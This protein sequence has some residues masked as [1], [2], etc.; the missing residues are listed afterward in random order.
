MTIKNHHSRTQKGGGCFA[1]WA[2]TDDSTF[3]PSNKSDNNTSITAAETLNQSLSHSSDERKTTIPPVSTNEREES[4]STLFRWEDQW[5]PVIPL[6]YLKNQI[7]PNDP[8][9]TSRRK[10]E[11]EECF[12]HLYFVCVV[13]TKSTRP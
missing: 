4:P 6:D 9:A 2:M 8:I 12:F 1:K 10:N 5:F 3:D 11:E 13:F 7:H